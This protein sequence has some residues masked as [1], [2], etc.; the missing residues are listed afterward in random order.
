METSVKVRCMVI[1]LHEKKT[2]LFKSFVKHAL[3][4]FVFNNCCINYSPV[5]IN[6]DFSKVKDDNLA[7]AFYFSV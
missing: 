3:N 5:H 4:S 6:S 7:L 1:I 2:M